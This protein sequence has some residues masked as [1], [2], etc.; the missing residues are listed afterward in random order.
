[1]ASGVLVDVEVFVN[2]SYGYDIRAEIVG[3]RGAVA[4]A[5]ADQE[6]TSVG[7]RRGG[8][9]PADW[10]ERFGRAFDAELQDWLRAA[11]AGTSAGPSCWDGYAATVVAETCVTALRTGSRTAAVMHRCPGFYATAER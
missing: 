9:I 10:R 6:R 2:A 7:G 11:A 5:E 8:R 1:M 4:L 3:E